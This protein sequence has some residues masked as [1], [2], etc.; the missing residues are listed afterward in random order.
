MCHSLVKKHNIYSLVGY[1][2]YKNGNKKEKEILEYD[3]TER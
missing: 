2:I 1:T 3:I